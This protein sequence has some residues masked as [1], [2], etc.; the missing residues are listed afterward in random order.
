MTGDLPPVPACVFFAVGEEPAAGEPE[1]GAE[2]PAP[3]DLI[4]QREAQLQHV[5]QR[6]AAGKVVA[7]NAAAALTLEKDVLAALVQVGK[8]L[9]ILQCTVC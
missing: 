3:A 9:R 1:E 5:Q 2:T 6:I 8:S 7:D 4:P